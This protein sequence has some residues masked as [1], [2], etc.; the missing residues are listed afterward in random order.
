MIKI[1]PSY[2]CNC[3]AC[4]WCRD[5]MP[6]EWES[7]T[8]TRTPGLPRTAPGLSRLA[9]TAGELSA[10]LTGHNHCKVLQTSRRTSTLSTPLSQPNKWIM[11]ARKTK[12]ITVN[13]RISCKK[14]VRT[15]PL[16]S[17]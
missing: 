14:S 17:E 5:V 11:F 10:P 9:R 4:Y 13:D 12:Q 7:Q 8:C 16:V 2:L 6:S 15:L 1:I 3:A